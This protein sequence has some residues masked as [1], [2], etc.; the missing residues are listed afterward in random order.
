MGMGAILV[1]PGVKALPGG[2]AGSWGE[3]PGA[4]VHLSLMPKWKWGQVPIRC[5]VF[6][7]DH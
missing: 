2:W 1:P 5:S 3:R 4:P 6:S 7:G